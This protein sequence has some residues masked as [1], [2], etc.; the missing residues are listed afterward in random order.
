MVFGICFVRSRGTKVAV[1]DAINRTLCDITF[2]LVLM[3]KLKKINNVS[4]I[5]FLIHTTFKSL[6]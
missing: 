2:F 4:N 1:H 6:D 3:E 5:F